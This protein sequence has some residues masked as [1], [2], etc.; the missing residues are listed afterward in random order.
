MSRIMYGFVGVVLLVAMFLIKDM[1][2][3]TYP[4]H[5]KNVA[6]TFCRDFGNIAATVVRARDR[7]TIPS[8]LL[9]EI[10]NSAVTYPIPMP[11]VDAMNTEIVLYVYGNPHV[12]ET[13]ARQR[14]ETL[15][16]QVIHEM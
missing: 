13:S 6:H 14:I 5:A 3:P 9:Q 12:T 15:C 11:G 16:H 2:N 4:A 10:R 1:V 8:L 7:G